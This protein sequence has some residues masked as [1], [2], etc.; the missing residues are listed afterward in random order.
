[1]IKIQEVSTQG[2]NKCKEA[3]QILEEE[4]K[5]QFS[6]VEVEY[7]DMLSEQGQKMVQEHGIMSSPGIIVNGKLF[8]IG[9]L[10]KDKLV[11][12]IQELS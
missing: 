10:D 11:T 6:N 2:C 9:G 4:I 12:K 5:P 7:I 1:M 3:K 8:S